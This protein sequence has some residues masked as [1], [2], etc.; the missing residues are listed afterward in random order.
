MSDSY[1]DDDDLSYSDNDEP[2]HSPSKTR[3]RKIRRCCCCVPKRAVLPGAPRPY[4]LSLVRRI[5]RCFL[6]MSYS[7]LSCIVTGVMRTTLF[8][9]FLGTLLNAIFVFGP[10]ILLYE[11]DKTSMTT[12]WA[13]ALVSWMVFLVNVYVFMWASLPRIQSELGTR[14]GVYRFFDAYLS[15]TMS[16]A[17]LGYSIWV[18][19]S[20]A[21]KVAQFQSIGDESFNGY[22]A[23]LRVWVSTL[24]TVWGTG[25]I[26]NNP[27]GALA[28]LWNVIVLLNSAVFLIVVAAWAPFLMNG[29]YPM[30]ATTSRRH[31]KKK[32]AKSRRPT[33]IEGNVRT[34][35]HTIAMDDDVVGVISFPNPGKKQR[36]SVY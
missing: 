26:Q 8:F 35:S 5:G 36:N 11:M 6:F 19:D 10:V 16:I 24:S 18:L 32:R 4:S 31:H 14:E 21:G 12:R 34:S 13:S 3:R 27:V 33:N 9:P 17:V 22:L 7:I 29:F 25:Y 20:S 28:L 15:S 23:F 2:P 30:T 1:S